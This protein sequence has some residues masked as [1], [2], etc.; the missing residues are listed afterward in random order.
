[1]EVNPEHVAK[2]RAVKP[3]VGR[4]AVEYVLRHGSHSP[5]VLVRM[6]TEIQATD[7]VQDWRTLNAARQPFDTHWILCGGSVVRERVANPGTPTRRRKERETEREMAAVDHDMLL[8][9]QNLEV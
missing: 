4:R 2:N 9:H 5:E 6:L 7:N 8:H 3:R 1:M